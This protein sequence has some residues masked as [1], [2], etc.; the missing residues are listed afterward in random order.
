MLM[1]AS[2]PFG[3]GNT[4]L[5]LFKIIAVLAV[6]VILIVFLIRFLGRRNRL[7]MSGRSIRTLGAMG[8]GPNKS[9][10]IIEVGGSLYVIGV[11]EDVTMLDKITDPAEVALIVSAF[12]DEMATQNNVL[13]PLIG[14]FKA[15]LRG[16][17]PSE[18]IELS[19][20]SSFYETLQS[21][22][23]LAPERKEKMDELLR[24]DAPRDESR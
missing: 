15:K 6:I 14:K 19:D 9:V 23:A 2:E 8:L 11:G 12:E 5:N 17:V 16:E 18:E 20:T 1:Y 10:Q 24:D 7:L 13:A 22:L 21:K 3:T 4:L